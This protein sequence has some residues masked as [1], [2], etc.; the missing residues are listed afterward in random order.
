MARPKGAKNK[1]PDELITEAA[2]A[3]RKAELKQLEAKRDKLAQKRR[4]TTVT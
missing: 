4:A 3:R 1:S 2:I